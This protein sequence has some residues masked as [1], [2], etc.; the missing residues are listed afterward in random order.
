MYVYV[1]GQPQ[2]C[3]RSIPSSTSSLRDPQ[4]ALAPDGEPQRLLVVRI[5]PFL[6]A[7]APAPSRGT[8]RRARCRPPRRAAAATSQRRRRPSAPRR[9][10]KSGRRAALVEVVRPGSSR[11]A[12]RPRTPDRRRGCRRRSRW[13]C[14]PA[15][16]RWRGRARRRS[17]RPAT[18]TSTAS[19][20]LGLKV[21]QPGA[22]HH[23]GQL[24]GQRA[25]LRLGQS[26]QRL[27]DVSGEAATHFSR[28]K[29]S[30][31]ARRAAR[32]ADG[33]AATTRLSRRSCRPPCRRRAAGPG[34]RSCPTRDTDR[35]AAR[36]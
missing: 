12:A 18:L 13:R 17:S 30:K 24:A 19:S 14:G 29:A 28:K 16:R 20:R 34:R 11:R 2:C 21:D 1:L 4:L 15:R 33:R 8:R 36:A 32:A 9:R 23:A 5:A 31:S 27:G 7:A 6:L 26:E 10:A 22:V 3:A 35:A 25:D